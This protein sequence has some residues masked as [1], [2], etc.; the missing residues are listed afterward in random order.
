MSASD[1]DSKIDMLESSERME[2]KL[3][4]AVCPEGKS[5]ADGNGVLAFLQFVIF[6]LVD[7][8]SDGGGF[9]YILCI[10]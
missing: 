6:P 2:S 9:R 5:A 8:V 4:Q 3:T 7:L 1:V 10:Y